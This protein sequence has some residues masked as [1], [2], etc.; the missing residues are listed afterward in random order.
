MSGAGGAAPPER[1][2]GN[3]PSH[4]QRTHCPDL[5]ITRA[6]L[7]PAGLS[8][9]ALV[10][11]SPHLSAFQNQFYLVLDVWYNLDSWQCKHLTGWAAGK[12]NS[13]PEE[14]LCPDQ[15]LWHIHNMG[16]S[17]H[18]G[19][20]KRSANLTQGT[21]AGSCRTPPALCLCPG[22]GQVPLPLAGGHMPGKRVLDF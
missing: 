21:G 8:R 22:P 17:V 10:T 4:C 12:K 7:N 20:W 5:E 1:E 6:R 16:F 15:P 3:R 18:L 13:K 2:L 11:P 14:Q 19:W 9:N